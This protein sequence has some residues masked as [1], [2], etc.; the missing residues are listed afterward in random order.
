M[1]LLNLYPCLSVCLSCIAFW[2]NNTDLVITWP[3]ER[4]GRE[5]NG[6]KGREAKMSDAA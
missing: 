6:L 1:F 5:I 3:R 2:G 4:K